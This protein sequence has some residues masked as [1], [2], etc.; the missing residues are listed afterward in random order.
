MGFYT[1]LAKAKMGET[2]DALDIIREYWGG[3]LKMGATTFWEDFDV[4]WTENSFR[5]DEPPKENMHDIHGDFG[6]HCYLQFRHSLCHGWASGPTAFLSGHVLGVNIEEAGCK[7]VRISPHLGN[8]SYV[9]GSYP[10][11]FG[12]IHIEHKS[13][14]GKITTRYTAPKEIEII[15]DTDE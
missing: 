14:N 5:I 4:K 13:E 7:R 11:P 9:K 10:T 3:M 8:L 2:S 12:E 15:V 1:L 6:K